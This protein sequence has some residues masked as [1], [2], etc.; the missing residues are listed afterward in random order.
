MKMFSDKGQN[1]ETVQ[2]SRMAVA[3]FRNFRLVC[4][5]VLN[6]VNRAWII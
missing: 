3:R 2:D 5:V 4:S 6:Q 1:S